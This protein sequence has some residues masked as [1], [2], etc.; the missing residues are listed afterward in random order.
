MK[1]AGTDSR[2]RAGA[3]LVAGLLV[4]GALASLAGCSGQIPGETP[5]AGQDAV[6]QAPVSVY[7][8]S[9]GAA[10]TSVDA[11][12]TQSSDGVATDPE[13]AEDL[14]NVELLGVG[15]GAD[16]HYVVVQFRAPARLVR[17]WQSGAVSV[18]DERNGMIYNDIPVVPV[19][20]A[21]FGKP[22]EDGQ[23]GY[24]MFANLPPLAKGAQV[25]VDL[26][27]FRQEHV[28]VQ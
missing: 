19:L 21:L 9:P 5:T 4:A 10:D 6:G 14:K 16:D 17:T 2:L 23:I 25:T 3:L 13:E 11:A 28:A 20:G 26:G 22:V 7:S 24:V 18:T 27:G 8:D 12:S 1:M 15:L